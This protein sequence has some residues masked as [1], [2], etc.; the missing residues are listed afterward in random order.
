MSKI[1]TR[2]LIQLAFLIACE[3]V[4]TRFCSINTPIVR[5]GFGFLPVAVA[6]ML[7]GP[8]WA[9]GAAALGDIIGVVLFPSGAFFPGYTLT[10]F[11][12]GFVYGALLHNK[13][14]WRRT[15]LAVGI[16]AL[17][18]NLGLDTLWL[19]MIT[20][21]GYLALFPT[22]I[23]KS[24]LMAPLQI[25]ALRLVSSR[26]YLLPGVAADKFARAPK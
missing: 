3:I 18:W 6:G 25:V 20:G 23:V 12:T 15:A 21:K 1:S 16:V 22:R 17:C 2:K 10:A 5:I 11:L 13:G 8:L 14:G 19:Y 24:V 7:F 9:G 4:L 26:L